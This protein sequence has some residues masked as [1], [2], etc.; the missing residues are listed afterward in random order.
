MKIQAKISVVG[1]GTNDDN[2]KFPTVVLKRTFRAH[3]TVLTS[4]H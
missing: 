3:M 1:A 2:L 4:H